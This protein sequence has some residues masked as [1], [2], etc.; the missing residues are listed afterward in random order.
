MMRATYLVL[1]LVAASQAATSR[2]LV[3]QSSRVVDFGPLDPVALDTRHYTVELENEH[4]RVV[5]V[6]YSARERGILHEHRCGRVTVFL[7]P[8]HQGLRRPNGEAIESR[9]NAGDARWGTADRHSDEN[10]ADA[11]IELVYVDVKSACGG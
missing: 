3:T 10:L 2:D 11:P 7:T 6:R 1:V 9:A 8:L 4:V 5:R